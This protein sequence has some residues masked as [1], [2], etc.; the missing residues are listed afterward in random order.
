MKN[1]LIVFLIFIF[2]ALSF[3]A[4]SRA[5]TTSGLVG[6]WT[7]DGKDT[8][9]RTS[10]TN[11]VS[12]QGNNGTL[13]SMSTT[14]TPVAGKIGQGFLFNGSNSYITGPTY[15][16]VKTVSFWIKPNS[17]TQ[18]IASLDTNLASTSIS[19]GTVLA[20]N[21]TSPTIYVDGVNTTT[22]GTGWHFVTITTATAINAS[23]IQIG[24]TGTGYY[25]GVLDDVRIYNR[26]LS[27]SD[28]AQLYKQGAAISR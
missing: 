21:F 25:A 6:R 12:G 10:K 4:G 15:N 27:A 18:E 2:S 20:N 28:V 16:G 11:D 13:T 26:A 22:I 23:A 3:P 8:N 24:K 17:T 19:N 14:T 9:W 7:F 5:D 1:L